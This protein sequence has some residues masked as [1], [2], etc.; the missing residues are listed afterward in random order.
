MGGGTE[1]VSNIFY[2]EKSVAAGSAPVVLKPRISGLAMPSPR[3]TGTT[4]G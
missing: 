4:C 2:G 3:T 1:H